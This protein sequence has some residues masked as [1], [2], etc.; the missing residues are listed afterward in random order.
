MLEKKEIY[1]GLGKRK[2]AVAKVFLQE[3]KGNIQVNNDDINK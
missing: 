3:G 1:T 2:T